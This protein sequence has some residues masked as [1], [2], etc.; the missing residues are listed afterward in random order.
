MQTPHPIRRRHHLIKRLHLDRRGYWM[1]S[2]TSA[3]R[4]FSRSIGSASMVSAP[5]RI[6][7]ATTGSAAASNRGRSDADRSA[8]RSVAPGSDAV[9]RPRRRAEHRTCRAGVGD[10]RSPHPCRRF[11]PRRLRAGRRSSIIFACVWLVMDGGGR[12]AIDQR[13]VEPVQLRGI[14]HPGLGQSVSLGGKPP[15]LYRTQDRGTAPACCSGGLS[16][17][18]AHLVIPLV[19]DQ[20]WRG[21]NAVAWPV[22]APLGGRHDQGAAGGP[23][24]Q[25]GRP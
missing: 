9:P 5:A 13:R 4:S 22:S 20:P 3:T 6:A 25:P 8:A 17:A 18:V 19:R 1:S 10:R 24:M 7:G 15:C 14:H 11:A 21:K 12:M 16:K 23:A 2:L